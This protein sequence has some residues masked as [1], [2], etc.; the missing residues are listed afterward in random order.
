MNQEKFSFKI[1]FI[2]LTIGAFVSIGTFPDND[3]SFSV[4]I[5]PP[6]AWLYNYTFEIKPVSGAVIRIANQIQVY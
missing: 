6:L 4:G 5:D 3:W 2:L 1:L